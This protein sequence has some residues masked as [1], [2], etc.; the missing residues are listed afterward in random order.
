MN[1]AERIRTCFVKSLGLQQSDTPRDHEPS[2]KPQSNGGTQSWLLCAPS[3]LCGSIG[4]FMESL[5]LQF[6]TRMGTMNRRLA[7]Q[8]LGLRQPSGAFDR[9]PAPESARGLAQSKTGRRGFMGSSM[10][11]GGWKRSGMKTRWGISS[12][13]PFSCSSSIVSAHFENEDEEKEIS[14]APVPRCNKGIVRRAGKA[15]CPPGQGRR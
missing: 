5:D 15:L 3:F 11:V 12:S 10:R 8:R 6:W 4:R 9:A 14:G 7:R 2:E 1:S 13:S